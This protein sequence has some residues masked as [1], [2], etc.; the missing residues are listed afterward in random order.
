MSNY[1]SSFESFLRCT[2]EKKIFLSYLSSY[3]KKL[4]IRSLL[5]IGAGNGTIAIP[6]SKKVKN[7]MA[8]E[9]NKSFVN[10]LK[11]E[12]I[13][14]IEE[15]F[16]KKDINLEGTF[17]MVL[18]SYVI[19]HNKNFKKFV[20][21]AWEYI[22]PRGYLLIVTHRQFHDE[23]G[24]F[25]KKIKFKVY[26]DSSS[27]FSNLIIYLKSLGEV[28]VKEVVTPVKSE[29]LGEFFSALAFVASQGDKNKESLFY[30]NKDK[31]D[32]IINRNYNKK[33]SYEFPFKHYFILCRKLI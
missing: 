2:N 31:I 7:Y 19:P 27:F 3:I 17:D 32:K 24:K 30:K 13:G 5:D 20:S 22:S 14:V 29:N 18:C 23:W 4:K 10:N 26:W 12:G 15:E 28:Y 11:S 33:K 8:I 6:L 21:K 1:K 9:K 16:P 25:C